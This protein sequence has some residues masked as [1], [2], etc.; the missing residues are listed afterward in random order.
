MDRGLHGPEKTLPNCVP[1]KTAT[2]A[3]LKIGLTRPREEL[4]DR[5]NRRVIEMMS[6]GL[7]EEARNLYPKRNLTAI[8][9]KELFKYSRR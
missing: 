3:I 7:E 8:G 5:I 2:F 1:I 6:D 9:Y 4:Y